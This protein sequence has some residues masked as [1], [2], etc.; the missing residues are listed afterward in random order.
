NL[1]NPELKFDKTKASKFIMQ[2]FSNMLNSYAKSFNKVNQRR[3]SVFIDYIRRLEIISNEQLCKTIVD[4]HK[5][6]VTFGNCSRIQQWKWSSFRNIIYNT[7]YMVSSNKV[8]KLFGGRQNFLTSHKT[9]K[10]P[11]LIR[12]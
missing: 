9:H 3:G 4:I 8:L 5:S 12:F 2:C 11:R 1:L 10:K 7:P 6:P